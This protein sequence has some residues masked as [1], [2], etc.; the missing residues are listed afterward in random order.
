MHRDRYRA[1]PKV[2][3]GMLESDDFETSSYLFY[4]FHPLSKPPYR[5]HV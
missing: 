1:P 3:I 2:I 4:Y 5:L